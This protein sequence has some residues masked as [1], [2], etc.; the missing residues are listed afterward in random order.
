MATVHPHKTGASLS[1]STGAVG[2]TADIKE[3]MD[4][5]ASCGTKVGK[6]DHVQGEEIKL[7]KS[8]SPD[9]QHHLIPL[10]WV[11]KV[12]DHIHLSKDHREVQEEW[13]PA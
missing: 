12:H 5:Y 2:S 11:A 4:V 7:T 6:V 10:S 1:E 8:D 13:Q 3:H 9:G